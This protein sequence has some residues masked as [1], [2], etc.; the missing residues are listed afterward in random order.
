MGKERLSGD[1]WQLIDTRDTS[2]IEKYTSFDWN[3]WERRRSSGGGSPSGASPSA[4]VLARG[5]LRRALGRTRRLGEG[6]PGEGTQ[7]RSDPCR[8]DELQG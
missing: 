1:I 3:E 8:E 4:C 7:E 6:A 5:N 2:F